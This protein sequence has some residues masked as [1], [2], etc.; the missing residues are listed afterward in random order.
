MALAPDGLLSTSVTPASVAGPPGKTPAGEAMAGHRG[1]HRR[2][3][4]REPP[5]RPLRTGGRLHQPLEIGPADPGGG[6]GFRTNPPVFSEPV[7]STRIGPGA[8][9]VLRYRWWL[10][11]RAYR[12][13][14][15]DVGPGGAGGAAEDELDL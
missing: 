12:S 4:G 2:A 9:L 10:R 1:T 7:R 8:S 11:G 15:L 5:A 14:R 6:G 13:H 3:P